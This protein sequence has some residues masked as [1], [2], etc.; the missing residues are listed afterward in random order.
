VEVVPG[1]ANP[2][3]VLSLERVQAFAILPIPQYAY[4]EGGITLRDTKTKLIID[5]LMQSEFCS[6]F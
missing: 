1:P 4:S 2:L 5:A 3:F 6:P